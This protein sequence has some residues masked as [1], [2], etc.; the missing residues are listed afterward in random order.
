MEE[1]IRLLKY[2]LLGLVQGLGE[3]L[4]ISSSGHL[5]LTYRLMNMTPD[6]SF[7]IFLHFASLIAIIIFFRKRL[8]ELIKDFF[9]FIFKRIKV[10]ENNDEETKEKA[11]LQKR[12]FF[13]CLYLILATIPAAIAGLFLS[14]IIEKYLSTLLFVGIFLII[15]AIL[16]AASYLFKGEREIKEMKWYDA[17][18]IGLFQCLGIMPGISRSGSCIVGGKVMRFKQADAAEF[19]FLMAIPIMLGSAIVKVPD[20]ATS[21]QTDYTLLLP[22]IVSFIITAA[23]TF[24]CLM[25]FLKIIRKRKLYIFSV[26]CALVGIASIVLY[27]AL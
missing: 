4:P 16:L 13:M 22:Y 10:D 21:L 19:A 6:L 9:L 15:T 3:I 23:V 11:A 17:L 26:Y 20:I 14:N 12:N 1:F 7:E 8:I 24:F 27:F 18:I 2:M 25:F 5:V